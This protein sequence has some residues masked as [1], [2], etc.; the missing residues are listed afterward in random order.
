MRTT[1]AE[2]ATHLAGR[3]RT[4]ATCIKI[5]RQDTTVYGFTSHD[6][7]IEF[8]GVTYVASLGMARSAIDSKAGMQVDN[9]E[10][11]GVLNAESITVEDLRAGLWDHA[12]IRV[13]EVNWRDLTMGS[14][15]QLRGWLGQVRFEGTRH[16]TEIRGL[17]SALNASVG[18][19]IS[20]ACQADVGDARC[21]V[22]MTDYTTTG[23]VT[24]ATSNRLFDTDLSGA[25]VRLTP[26]TTGAPD[27]N[28]FQAG[29][30]TWLTGANAGRRMEVKAYAL[31]GE[32]ELQLAME[33]D[34][35]AGDT[36]TITA[37][38]DKSPTVC[39][40]RYGNRVNF[41]GFDMLP[42]IDKMLRV[43]GQ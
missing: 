2:L 35:V 18:E 24:A 11:F 1:S 42:G 12:E 16:H 17:A 39:R 37:G 7:D 3:G 43:G 14:L 30:V 28:Y 15:K 31:D 36:F 29:F 9:L 22:D 8:D 38:C 33:G 10:A 34:V 5:T 40:V 20:P 32:V 21:T 26:T 4:L 6:R 25:V 23:E 27:L 19:L 41:R 13:F